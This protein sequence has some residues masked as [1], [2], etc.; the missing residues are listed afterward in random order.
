MANVPSSVI[1][2]SYCR[3]QLPVSPPCASVLS[4]EVTLTVIL[5]SGVMFPRTARLKITGSAAADRMAGEVVRPFS[6]EMSNDPSA[7]SDSVTS[8]ETSE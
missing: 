5:P 4:A 3:A 6:P 8:I 7:F 2:D 1:A